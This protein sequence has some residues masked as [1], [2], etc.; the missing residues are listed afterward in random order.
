VERS[1]PSL[2]TDVKE[3]R[4]DP[5]EDLENSERLDFGGKIDIDAELPGNCVVRFDSKADELELCC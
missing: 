5:P 4:D 3:V 1:L 2:S